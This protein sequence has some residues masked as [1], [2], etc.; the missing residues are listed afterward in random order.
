MSTSMPHLRPLAQI[1]ARTLPD[2]WWAH[3]GET[4]DEA[5]ARHILDDLLDEIAAELE[6]E[7]A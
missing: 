1:V 7:A 3:P 2:L 5:A 4:P 6:E